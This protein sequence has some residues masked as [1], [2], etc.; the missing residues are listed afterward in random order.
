MD[1]QK[2]AIL[3]SNLSGYSAACQRAL[4]KYY[5]VELLVMY[6]PVASEAPFSDEIFGHIDHP[7]DRSKLST[8]EIIKTLKDFA[9]Q[10]LLISG[11]MDKGY[12]KAAKAMKE[13]GVPVVAGSD[14][15]WTGSFRQQVAVRISQWYLHPSI[16]ILWATGE[17]QR[18]F[19]NKLGYPTKNCWSGFYSCDWEKF[20][21]AK[22]EK[23]QKAFLYV[24]RYLERKGLDTLIEAYKAYRKTVQ[25]PWELWLIGKGPLAERIK[26][27]EGIKDIGFVQPHLVPQY[28]KKVA[29]FIFPSVYEPWGVALHEAAAAGLPLIASD[30]VGAAVHLLREGHNGYLFQA[31]DTNELKKKLVKVANATPEEWQ[32]M[33][34]ASF[35]LSKQYTPKHWARIFMEGIKEC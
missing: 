1:I 7:Y 20:A 12:L 2:I 29:C 19:A 35:E 11:W 17:R 16:D 3:Y 30:A 21:Y 4:K 27:E 15:Q 22:A 32:E 18:Q 26:G 10:A 28:Y 25:S 14:T 9:P 31:K 34:Q 8:P 33:S 23:R 6:W 13:E 24:G 5:Q